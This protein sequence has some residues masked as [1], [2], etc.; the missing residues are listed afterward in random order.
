MIGKGVRKGFWDVGF[1]LIFDLEF[2]DMVMFSLWKFI[3]KYDLCIFL[4]VCYILFKRF[5]LKIFDVIYY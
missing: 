1:I 4:F 3:K 5:I 2:G